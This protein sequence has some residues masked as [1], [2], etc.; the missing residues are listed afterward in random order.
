MVQNPFQCLKRFRPIEKDPL[1][2]HATESLAAC[3]VFSENYR[4]KF[5][6]FLFGGKSLIPAALSAVIQV[7]V[8]TQHVIECGRLDLLLQVGTNFGVVVEVKVGADQKKSQLH[9]HEDW[10]QR[11]FGRDPRDSRDRWKLFM[12]VRKY[13]PNFECDAAIIYTWDKLHEFTQAIVVNESDGSTDKLMLGAFCEFLSREGVVMNADY[14][15]LVEYGKGWTAEKALDALFAATRELVEQDVGDLLE[16]RNLQPKG[17]VPSFQFGR[18]AWA[19]HFGAAGWNNKVYVWIGTSAN[20]AE[21]KSGQCKF[22]FVIWLWCKDHG[23][24]W[25]VIR[26]RLPSWLDHLGQKEG[27]AR[28]EFKLRSLPWDKAQASALDERRIYRFWQGNPLLVD[29]ERLKDRESIARELAR[30]VKECIKLV[31]GLPEVP[32]LPA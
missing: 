16:P 10:L 20:D 15:K 25:N 23:Q 8:L 22:Q 27:R 19:K 21:L 32:N 5:L 18:K 11:T 26:T 1:E 31:D 13:D 12:L 24:D 14:T 29:A 6:E 7:E 30:R 3:L 4:A 17:G 28:S 2:D 9:K